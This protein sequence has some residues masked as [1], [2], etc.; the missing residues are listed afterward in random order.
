M[1]SD[2]HL[3]EIG[4]SVQAS[5]SNLPTKSDVMEL[6]SW[7]NCSLTQSPARGRSVPGRPMIGLMHASRAEKCD[8]DVIV[9]I[10]V[11]VSEQGASATY[12]G[13]ADALDK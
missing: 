9:F 4:P 2:V 6:T 5:A 11:T 10:L 12:K 8:T 1:V 7:L 3:G 13:E